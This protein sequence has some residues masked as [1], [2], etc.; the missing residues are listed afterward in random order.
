M[1]EGLRFEFTGRSKNETVFSRGLH[2]EN[3]N[4]TRYAAGLAWSPSQY[5]SVAVKVN[6]L[7][8]SRKDN[9]DVFGSGILS[10]FPND[11]LELTVSYGDH[12]IG[13]ARAFMLGTK[14]DLSGS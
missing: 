6:R 8:E 1:K 10:W 5:Y 3:F 4:V 12:P 7:S 2:H 14:I 13:G 9:E 11:D